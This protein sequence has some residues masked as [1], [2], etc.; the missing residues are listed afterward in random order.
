M[1]RK[2]RTKEEWKAT[3]EAQ[4]KSVAWLSKFTHSS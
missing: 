1:P 4:K 3:L 2:R